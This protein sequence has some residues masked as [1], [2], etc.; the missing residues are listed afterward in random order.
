MSD[1]DLP[2]IRLRV[3]HPSDD[4]MAAVLAA[5]RG[6]PEAMVII[7][8]WRRRLSKATR[9]DPVECTTCPRH[10][11]PRDFWIVAAVPDADS[12]KARS[13]AFCDDCAPTQ[14]RAIEAGVREM[15]KTWRG[16]DLRVAVQR[17]VA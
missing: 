5:Q 2:R 16:P 9:R 17:G 7:Q 12:T 1:A 14:D 4:A 15:R 10:L 13:W 6:E 3:L 8:W 11:R